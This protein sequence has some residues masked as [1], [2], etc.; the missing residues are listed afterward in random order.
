MYEPRA[1]GYPASLAGLVA[2]LAIYA[3]QHIPIIGTLGL[4]VGMPFWSILLVN[5]AF[6]GTAVEVLARRIHPAWL[7]APLGWFGFYAWCVVTE[8]N[9]V[10]ELGTSLAAHN[11]KV[12]VAFDPA[13]LA[14]VDRGNEGGVG[15]D[16]LLQDYGVPVVYTGS[17]DPKQSGLRATRLAE[18][19]FCKTIWDDP[20]VRS[21][22]IWTSGFQ[23]EVPGRIIGN[24]DDRFCAISMPEQP[25]IPE[26]VLSTRELGP[27]K[28]LPHSTLTETTIALPDG[29]KYRLFGGHAE[30]L[31]W[32]PMPITGCIGDWNQSSD[33]DACDIGFLRPNLVP[34]VDK[35]SQYL[36]DVRSLAE[37]F[38][39]ASRG[40]EGRQASP[41]SEIKDLIARQQDITLDRQLAELHKLI[42][43]PFARTEEWE[44]GMLR[45]NPE[46]YA[47]LAP[48]I[49][50]AF[51]A[52]VTDDYKGW[53]NGR[54]LSRVL[55]D[56][57]A[58]E[59]E[60]VRPV[61]E[62]A[63]RN[64]RSPWLARNTPRLRARLAGQDP[65]GLE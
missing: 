26:I 6:L 44:F 29:R 38:G 41:T 54:V 12:H 9:Q 64:D 50:R 21:A 48:K 30:T 16:Y 2:T 37:A 39:L 13:K 28:D 22:Q 55:S 14:L 42:I 43:D 11:A 10:A 59:F 8:H 34:L 3:I 20:E 52:T 45:R 23:D 53:D 36:S 35:G 19:A 65:Q 51:A 33:R 56:L 17:T 63:Y 27:A 15:A 5:A 24:F 62:A 18:M 60:A 46:R 40:R 4:L 58:K 49:A 57:P 1:I 47:P 25:T 32:I 61:I 31:P 7:L